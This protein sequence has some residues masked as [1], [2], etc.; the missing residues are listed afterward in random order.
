MTTYSL[1]GTILDSEGVK[2]SVGEFTCQP[3]T[4]R[5]NIEFYR[6]NGFTGALTLT[7]TVYDG[8]KREEIIKLG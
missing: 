3:E 8:T 1:T 7:R 5:R 4:N 2:V 6:T